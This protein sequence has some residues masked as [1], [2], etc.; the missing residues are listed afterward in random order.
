MDGLCWIQI[1]NML[2]GGRAN[3][4]HAAAEQR[5]LTHPN[6]HFIGPAF[7]HRHAAFP[8]RGFSNFWLWLMIRSTPE[9]VKTHP[10]SDL[11]ANTE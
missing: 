10:I 8:I 2:G 1:A 11:N 3:P 5:T 6:S 4:M 9:A 7:M